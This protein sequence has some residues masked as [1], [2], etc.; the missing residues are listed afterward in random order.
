MAV[1]LGVRLAENPRGARSDAH[2][3]VTFWTT[4]AIVAEEQAGAAHRLVSQELIG[5]IIEELE[6][7]VAARATREPGL[8]QAAASGLVATPVMAV[9]HPGESEVTLGRMY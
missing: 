6:E 1:M 5:A 7:A 3:E 8:K 2:P 4:A 9:W